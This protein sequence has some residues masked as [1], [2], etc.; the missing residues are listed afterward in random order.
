MLH[1]Y[2]CNILHGLSKT[3]ISDR[4]PKFTRHFWTWLFKSL[5]TNLLFSLVYHPQ[6][7][8]WTK[9]V[10]QI[11]EQTIWHYI[12]ARLASWEDNLSLVEFAYNNS[13]HP[14]IGM[15]PFQEAYGHTPLVPTNFVFKHSGIGRSTSSKA[16]RCAWKICDKCNRSIRK[17]PTNIVDMQ[18]FKEI[19]SCYMW[20]L[21][22][23]KLLSQFCG[24]G[25]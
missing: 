4:D 14:A 24:K 16:A 23:T 11:L 22:A 20:H 8:G 17:R 18:I 19:W 12:Q 2:L 25:D 7:D 21:I 9:I 1:H 13:H 3:V 15:I 5:G 6:T 10:N